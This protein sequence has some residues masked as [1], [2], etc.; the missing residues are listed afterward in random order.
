MGLIERY[1]VR[2]TAVAFVATLSVLL[3]VV[4]VTQALRQLDLVTAK[5]QAI[6]AFL[7]ITLLAVPFLIL[8]IAPFAVVIAVV[9]V[10]STMNGDSELVV[11][12]AAGASRWRVL[13][14]ILLVGVAVGLLAAALSLWAAP[15]GLRA[16]REALSSVRVDLVAS[17]IRPG[18]FI[19]IDDGLTFHIRDR[20]QDGAIAG[21]LLD[22]E[23]DPARSMTYLAERGTIVEAVGKTLLVMTDGTIQRRTI[24]NGGLQIV[25]F[26]AYA[27]DLTNLTPEDEAPVYRPSERPTEALLFPDLADTY[28]RDNLGRIRAEVH[29]RLTQPLY[30]IAFALVVFL[31]LGEPRTTRQGRALGILGA[32][33]AVTALR[34]AGFGAATLAIRFPAAVGIMYAVPLVAIGASLTV[35]LSDMRLFLPVPVARAVDTLTDVAVGIAGRAAGSGGR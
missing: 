29:D 33:A 13:K 7:E 34:L 3:G 14:P 4:W 28:V 21:I 32:I 17:I 16:V 31:F 1:I 20:A 12:H 19:E 18:R 2:R 30:P 25:R 6:G 15:A 9:V 22:D 8:L 23:R 11:M 24:R 10:L 5:G 27:F 26:D 35:I